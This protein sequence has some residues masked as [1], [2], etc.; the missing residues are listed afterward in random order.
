MGFGKAIC[1]TILLLFQS[2]VALLYAQSQSTDESGATVLKADSSYV[3]VPAL[4]KDKAGKV[5]TGVGL[6]SLTLLDNG[7]HEK[8]TEIDTKGL[9]ISLVVLMQTGNSAK[10][11]LRS[12]VNLPAMIGNM[13]GSSVHEITLITFDS[14]VK[15]I[16]HFPT[17][18]DGVD[19]AITHQQAGDGGAAIKD[20]LAFGVGQLQ[21]EP[22]KFRRVVILIS[23]QSDLGSA[24]SS[25]TLLEQLGTSSTV[26]YSLAFH[27]EKSH[28]IRKHGRNTKGS[29]ESAMDR[30]RRALD[31]QTAQETSALTGGTSYQFQDEEEFDSAMIQLLSDF[32][33]GITLGFQPNQHQRGFHQIDLRSNA[34]KLDVRARQA[35][36]S[37]HSE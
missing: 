18:T 24:T 35:Y 14:R 21:N 7:T 9:P 2:P 17:Q 13:V 34:R 29:N 15:E 26:V 28:S 20:A 32:H 19:W 3:W 37:A 23:Q 11:Y 36:W 6:N 33:N 12:Y 4:V 22:G 25:Q 31:D 5:A 27:G 16:W 1:G 8:V 30:S 10:N